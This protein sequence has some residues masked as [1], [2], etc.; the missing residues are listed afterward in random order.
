MS[1]HTVVVTEPD[2]AILAD[3]LDG[4]HRWPSP[5]RE[6]ARWLAR[7]LAAAAV[8]DS[9]AIP[10]DVVTLDSRVRIR[11]LD[12]GE[13]ARLALV[14][15]AM[16]FAAAGAISVL[17]PVG[18]D[19][20]PPAPGQEP[21]DRKTVQIAQPSGQGLESGRGRGFAHARL[22]RGRR[23]E[24]AHGRFRSGGSGCRSPK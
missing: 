14:T 9:D 1:V 13:E 6:H 3:L 17:S 16:A 21:A 24:I 22:G 12:S 7:K 10:G 2:M 15:P 20:T 5:G 19:E 18:A 4:E 11:D 23:S 8:V